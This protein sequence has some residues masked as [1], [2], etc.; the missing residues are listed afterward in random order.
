MIILDSYH[1]L[2]MVTTSAAVF[3]PKN[4]L[5]R[6]FVPADIRRRYSFDIR[7]TKPYPS[8]GHDVWIGR[9]VTLSMG[10]TVGT[11]SVIA[12]GSV[13]TRS[14][15][16]YAIVGGNP[17]RLIRRRFPDDICRALLASRWW[18]YA[19]DVVLGRLPAND[20]DRFCALLA[21]EEAAGHIAPFTPQAIRVEPDTDG[22]READEEA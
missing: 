20:P 4:P 1:P 2:A 10:I 22:L 11:G 8:I 6:G 18:R 14:V 9:N 15:E 7:G 19:P 17:A 21:E 3:R 13:V 5:F 16:P 12:A